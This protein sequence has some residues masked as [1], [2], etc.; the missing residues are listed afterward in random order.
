M[1]SVVRLFFSLLSYSWHIAFAGAKMSLLF[2]YMR[3]NMML[4]SRL[5]GEIWS[6]VLRSS[7]SFDK[8]ENRNI[9]CTCWGG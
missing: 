2:L 6:G 5:R 9:I 4:C 8:T 1:E 3:S 7:L